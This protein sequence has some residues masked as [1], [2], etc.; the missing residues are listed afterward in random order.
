MAKYREIVPSTEVDI[1]IWDPTAKPPLTHVAVAPT[2]GEGGKLYG[3]IHDFSD[4]KH[5]TLQVGWAVVEYP[6][7]PTTGQPQ[8]QVMP[9]DV[10]YASYELVKEPESKL[11]KLPSGVGKETL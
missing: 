6:P 1:S 3:V 8:Y 2:L 10:A 4:G 11:P 5:L 9:A 7:H